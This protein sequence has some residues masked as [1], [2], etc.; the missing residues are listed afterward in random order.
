[1]FMGFAAYVKVFAILTYFVNISF[2]PY[3]PFLL[4]IVIGSIGALIAFIS[5]KYQSK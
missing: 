1:M 5:Y 2:A 3:A 4:F